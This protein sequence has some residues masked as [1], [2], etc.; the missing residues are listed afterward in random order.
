MFLTEKEQ[1]NHSS[2]NYVLDFIFPAKSL[3]IPTGRDKRYIY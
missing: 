3:G 2:V 1:E